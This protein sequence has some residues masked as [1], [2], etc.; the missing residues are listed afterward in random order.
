MK[1]FY[2]LCVFSFLALN[3]LPY[4]LAD[5]YRLR[6]GVIYPL[7]GARQEE[8]TYMRRGFELGLSELAKEVRELIDVRFEDNQYL[9]RQTTTAWQKLNAAGGVDVV[10]NNSAPTSAALVSLTEQAG[11]TLLSVA[12]SKTLATG[13]HAAFLF[14]PPRER[15]VEAAV[16]YLKHANAK[17][18][19]IFT[20]F[21]E[22]RIAVLDE[23]DRQA[24]DLFSKT[25]DEK[26]NPDEKDFKI[27]VGRL[28]QQNEPDVILVNLFFGQ[29]GLF[30]KQI[31][32]LGVTTPLFGFEM[33]EDKGEVESAEG[34]L[35]GSHYVGCAG[36]S[37]EFRDAFLRRYPG[38]SLYLVPLM[39]DLAFVLGDIAKA[40]VEKAVI[41]TFI[42]TKNSFSG[43]LGT[44]KLYDQ[45]RFDIPVEVREVAP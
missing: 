4:A 18:I 36:G 10:I 31:R 2:C 16:E 42:R 29:V 7:S 22:G 9:P 14:Y 30:A 24:R 17:K 6:V 38:S 37:A 1:T 44:Y 13:K 23:F 27:F 45:N 40:K 20:T 25:I 33:M 5:E 11:V 3:T 32:Q 12:A 15:L 39:H 41:P 34:A 8:A 26:V 21:S 43:V 35:A 19:A 28:K